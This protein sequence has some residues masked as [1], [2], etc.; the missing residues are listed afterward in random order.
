[1]DYDVGMNQQIDDLT[2]LNHFENMLNNFGMLDEILME[3]DE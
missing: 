3:L 2:K 1:M